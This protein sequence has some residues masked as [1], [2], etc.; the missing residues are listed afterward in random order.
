MSRLF[1]PFAAAMLFISN[2]YPQTPQAKRTISGLVSA[3]DGSGPLEGVVVSVK[4]APITSGSQQ[5][6]MYY[7][8]VPANDSI[9]VFSREE[10]QTAEVRLCANT[11]YNVAL[12]PGQGNAP[13]PTPS[14]AQGTPT[15]PAPPAP[16]P[17][18]ALGSWRGLF[19]LRPGVEVPFNFDIRADKNGQLKAFF[20]N[21]S[22]SFE[23][24]PVR[25]TADSLFI[26]LDQF[27]NELAFKT[28]EGPLSG[29]FTKQDR[30]G[31]P[32]PVKIEPNSTI[33]FAATKATPAGDIS[34][35]YDVTFTSAEGKEEKVVGLFHQQGNKLTGTFLR[36]TGD[37]RYL[38]GIVEGNDFYLSSF[39]GS[40]P[41]YYRGHFTADGQIT[42]ENIGARGSQAF[43]GT[44]N[45]SAALPNPYTLTYLKPGYTSFD[46]TLPDIDGNTI[47][48]KDKK[49]HNKV[50]IVTIGGTWCPN[51]VDETS[52]LAPWY[53]ENKKRGVEI[54]SIQYERKTDT[55]FVRKVLTR[56]R[57][58]Y[59]IQYTQVFGGVADKQVVANSLPALNTFLA[60]PTTILIDKQGRVA[61]IHTG[62][63][64]PA[65]GSYY[66]KFEQEFNDKVDALLAAK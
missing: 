30:T 9:L 51:C 60:F 23:G 38:E 2:V 32:L 49:F 42:G 18:S 8:E 27:D 64:G 28:G 17:F 24:G 4:G 61:E 53:A 36:V 29:T 6:G 21:G 1:L 11:E 12:K 46:F 47:S 44:K 20:K 13:A 26:F 10:Y 63:S 65:T 40:G 16:A 52:F 15:A 5:D 50:V 34:G 25:Q 33:R 7:I 31:T 62:Y 45:D 48:L 56:M 22:E 66:A 57:D 58:R 39:Y 37:S 59:A 19:E 41:A 35:T 43:K 55:A 3:S 54:I 14:P